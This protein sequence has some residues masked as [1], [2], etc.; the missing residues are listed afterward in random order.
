LLEGVP[1][2]AI[3]ANPQRF[4][5]IFDPFYFAQTVESGRT[6]T[7]YTNPSSLGGFE[8]SEADYDFANEG[9]F[10]IGEVAT[11]FYGLGAANDYTGG[12]L[13]ITGKSDAVAC[14]NLPAPDCGSGADSAPAQAGTFFPKADYEVSIPDVT[15]HSISLHT[16]AQQSF[17]VAH[18]FLAK[19]GF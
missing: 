2:P 12:V 11:I 8:Q 10:S 18:D 13:A 4:S 14:N 16:S 1:A 9:T 3:G 5:K 6:A 7:F 15:G 19:K 17:K